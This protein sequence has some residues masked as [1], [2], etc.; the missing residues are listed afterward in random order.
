VVQ[1]NFSTIVKLQQTLE[2]AGIDFIDDPAGG[3]GCGS[4]G[5][6]DRAKFPWRRSF[7]INASNALCLDA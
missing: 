2:R 3:L 6:T 4:S 5:Q 1:G 7:D